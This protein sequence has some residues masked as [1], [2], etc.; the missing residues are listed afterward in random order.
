MKTKQIFWLFNSL[1]T[2][3]KVKCLLGVYVTVL[4]IWGGC[5]SGVPLTKPMVSE[6]KASTDS[7]YYGKELGA[8]FQAGYYDSTAAW[9]ALDTARTKFF[10]QSVAVIRSEDSMG[11]HGAQFYADKVKALDH[12]LNEITLTAK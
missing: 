6:E 12:M 1:S 4:L 11:I 5:S 9:V 2:S 8:A 7:Y 10:G 3:T